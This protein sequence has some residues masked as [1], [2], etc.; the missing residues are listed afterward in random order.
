MLSSLFCQIRLGKKG[1]F[2]LIA[3]YRRA[4]GLLGTLL[5]RLTHHVHVPLSLHYWLLLTSRLAM[6]Y[7]RSAWAW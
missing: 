7:W 6:A 5:D 4:R 2:G 1:I 3:L